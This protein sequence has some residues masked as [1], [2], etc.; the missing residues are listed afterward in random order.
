[1]DIQ[2]LSMGGYYYSIRRE[3]VATVLRL[4]SD[5]NLYCQVVRALISAGF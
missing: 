1:M 3:D 2:L 5:T 4:E